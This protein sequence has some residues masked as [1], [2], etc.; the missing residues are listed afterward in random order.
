MA[1]VRR[2]W[3]TGRMV[4]S[5]RILAV[6]MG[7]VLIGAIVAAVMLCRSSGDAEDSKPPTSIVLLLRK[8]RTLE[9]TTVSRIVSSTFDVA[10]DEDDPDATEFVVGEEPSFIANVQGYVF[11]FHCFPQPYFDDMTA[12]AA[13]IRELRIRKAFSQHRAWMSVDLLAAPEG[14]DTK[15]AYQYIGKMASALVDEDCVA[16]LAPET[17][18]VNVADEEVIAGLSG[19]DPL[20]AI[21][22]LVYPA[23]VDISDDD[24]RMKAAVA[25]ARR[26]WPQFV[27]AFE[28]RKEGEI[29]A[30]KTPF[31]EGKD[32]EFMWTQ[33]TAIEGG[34]IHGILDSD[35][36]HI[37]RLKA[38]DRVQVKLEDLNDW[39]YIRDGRMHG[40]FTIKVLTEHMK[41]K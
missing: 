12:A 26:K 21:A 6:V 33:V 24:P 14:K 38:G 9:R 25:E 28:G 41:D 23:M 19:P 18:A 29:F 17:G 22:E 27:K 13:A 10:F 15:E 39:N 32:T 11:V 2:L 34:A 7:L 16:I 36:V 5:R 1:A 40:G 3:G 8:P 35:P 30:V 4:G 20:K 37:T 31:T